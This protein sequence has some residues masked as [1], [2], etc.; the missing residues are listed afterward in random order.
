MQRVCYKSVLSD[1][2]VYQVLQ[3]GGRVLTHMG[4]RL[5][6]AMLMIH[7]IRLRQIHDAPQL[8]PHIF[9]NTIA[10]TL[11]QLAHHRD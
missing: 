3:P 4:A 10:R 9:P 2:S 7:V 11:D 8:F 5:P 6:S 1:G